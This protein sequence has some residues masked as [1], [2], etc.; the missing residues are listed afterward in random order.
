MIYQVPDKLHLEI[1]T[2]CPLLCSKCPRTIR[3]GQ[4]KANVDM[5]LELLS[6]ILDNKT[7]KIIDLCGSLG[8]PIFHPEFHK[9]FEKCTQHSSTV[10]FNT[11]G[12]GKTDK[13]WS[14]TFAIMRKT[15]YAIFGIDGLKDTHHLYRVNQDWDSVFNAMK[16]GKTLKKNIVWQWIPFRF[17]EHQIPEAKSIANK[18]RIKFYILKSNRWDQNDPLQPLN[19]TLFVDNDLITSEINDNNNTK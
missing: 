16:M 12:S 13:W 18:Y 11:A 1:T 7:F 3:K 5:S 4:F 10:I 8:D 2:R 17:N 9:I 14:D 19:P 15:D 6:R